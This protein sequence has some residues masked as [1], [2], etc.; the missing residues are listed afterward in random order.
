V[1]DVCHVSKLLDE[2][3]GALDCDGEWNEVSSG[4]YS[5]EFSVDKVFWEDVDEQTGKWLSVENVS[6]PKLSTQTS[7][8]CTS[9]V[10]VLQE[11]EAP[12]AGE[13]DVHA[14][15]EVSSSIEEV[16]TTEVSGEVTNPFAE[17]FEYTKDI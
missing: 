14:P 15:S 6:T 9:S 5:E 11:W 10:G 1:L 17:R 3:S 8:G 16:P 7:T 2:P 4:E 12:V 13:W